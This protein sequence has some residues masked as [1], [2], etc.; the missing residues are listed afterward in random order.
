MQMPKQGHVLIQHHLF[1]RV[2]TGE[3]LQQDMGVAEQELILADT[4]FVIPKKFMNISPQTINNKSK[5]QKNERRK[6]KR[7]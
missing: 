6:Q 1:A 7:S 3:V 2:G 4:K 5:G